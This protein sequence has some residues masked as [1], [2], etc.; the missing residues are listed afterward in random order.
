MS[1]T[2]DGIPPP[3]TPKDSLR[4]RRFAS[5]RTI[6][7]LMLREMSTRYG[8]SPGGYIWAILEPLGMTIM[9]AIAFSLLLR[10]PPLG[11][12]FILFKATGLLPFMLYSTVAAMVGRAIQFSRPLLF[13]PGVTWLDAI[14]ARF[15]LNALTTVLASYLILTGILWYTDTRTVIDMGPVA[16]SM[17]LAA[18]LGLGVGCLNC[19]LFLQYPLWEQAWGILTRPL[20]IASGVLFLFE[21]MPRLARDILWYNPLVHVTGLMRVGFYPIYYGDYISVLYV[22]VWALVPLVLGLML[23][24]RHHKTLLN[25]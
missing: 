17:S 5:L 16:L 6:A 22:L 21:D 15:A 10:S 12:S 11:T 14:L 25:L 1:S 13:Y 24:R 19:Y 9:L 8:R 7:A 20:L 3:L 18:M 2:A 4:A 23:L